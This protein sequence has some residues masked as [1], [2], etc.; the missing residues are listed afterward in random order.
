[1]NA[2]ALL[3]PAR[4]YFFQSHPSSILFFRSQRYQISYLNHLIMKS[5]IGWRWAAL[6]P[7][8]LF[9]IGCK[10][11]ITQTESDKL[12]QE[13]GTSSPQGIMCIPNTIH[14]LKKDSLSQARGAAYE[15]DGPQGIG[16]ANKILIVGG[17]KNDKKT[18]EHVDIY[19]TTTDSWT[20]K[21]LSSRRE[22][23][24]LAAAGTKIGIA[25]G[26][27]PPNP[28][29]QVDIY[30]VSSEV[31]T[32]SHLSSP[33]QGIAGVGY[34]NSLY[35]GGGE[36]S[37][38][39]S[40]IVNTVDVYNTLTD[41]WSLLTMPHVRM[42]AAA[43]ATNNKIVFA[44]GDGVKNQN[45]NRTAT[46]DIYDVPTGTWSTG[47][48]SLA[49]ENLSATALGDLIIFSGGD[50]SSTPFNTIDIYNT[51]T[52]TWSVAQPPNAPSG[53]V[54][55]AA[56]GTK[57]FFGRQGKSSGPAIVIVYDICSNTWTNLS[58]SDGRGEFAIGAAGGEV[59]FG[60][61]S[62]GHNLNPNSNFDPPYSKAVDIFYLSTLP[63]Q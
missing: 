5:K 54:Q 36:L 14:Y 15:F 12:M 40:M 33:R 63:I 61:G 31:W 49:R 35:F 28:T 26:E 19:N 10:K 43:A 9:F 8:S 13:N 47:H 56:Q 20:V 27:I 18:S 41:T 51:T 37:F 59:L 55:S 2:S 30:D 22:Q 60:G 17:V 38:G 48:L 50:N 6:I 42:Y 16:L 34:G 23:Y 32:V 44:G 1:M 58:L 24:A 25:G 11:D 52:G 57:M 29:D 53:R 3:L 4:L 62:F 39:G 46:A 21:I 45:V 7:L